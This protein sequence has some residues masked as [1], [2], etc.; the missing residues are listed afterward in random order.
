MSGAGRKRMS[1]SEGGGSGSKMRGVVGGI[2][3]LRGD[4][5]VGSG[6]TSSSICQQVAWGRV[7]SAMKVTG[8]PVLP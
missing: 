7:L 2:R 1:A 8:T 5:L 6:A 4:T 3:S